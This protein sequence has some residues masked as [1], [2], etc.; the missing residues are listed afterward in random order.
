[1]DNNKQYDEYDMAELRGRY[2][3]AGVIMNDKR[4]MNLKFSKDSSSKWDVAFYFE[5]H[6]IV[7]EIK[8]REGYRHNSWDTW[9]A[10]VKK[11]KAIQNLAHKVN[12]RAWYISI[13]LDG[14]YIWDVTNLD[15]NLIPTFNAQM[16]LTTKGDRT[17][18]NKDSVFLHSNDAIIKSN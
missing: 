5:G 14:Y 13:T 17:I 18:I 1:M 7:G 10:E 12:S 11:I 15:L 3:F 2:L 6:K 16:P 9:M 4:F 8:Y